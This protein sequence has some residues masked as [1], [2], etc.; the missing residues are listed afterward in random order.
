MKSAIKTL[1]VAAAFS[2]VVQGVRAEP[3]KDDSVLEAIGVKVAQAER[4][5][6]SLVS[7]FTDTVGKELSQK[8]EVLIEES[9][10]EAAE[11]VA[12]NLKST[13]K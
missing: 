11:F 2:A 4:E 12:E 3:A 6:T 10:S 13:L 9:I 5:V 1:V 7:D 8:I